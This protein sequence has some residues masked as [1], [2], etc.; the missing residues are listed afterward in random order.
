MGDA[1]RKR[2]EVVKAVAS[3]DPVRI[4]EA[5]RDRLLTLSNELSG[6]DMVLRAAASSVEQLRAHFNREAESLMTA[7]GLPRGEQWELNLAEGVIIRSGP[8]T[9]PA[10]NA[11][12]VEEE[13]GG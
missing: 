7:L 9:P 6:A 10:A 2:L 12:G 13:H 8:Q 11:D 3:R 5:S 4:S 1:K